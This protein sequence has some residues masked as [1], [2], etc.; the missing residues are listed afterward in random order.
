VPTLEGIEIMQLAIIYRDGKRIGLADAAP[1]GIGL[2]QWFHRNCAAYSMDHAIQHEGYSVEYVE[3]ID[4][5]DVESLIGDICAHAG[6][7]MEAAFVPFSRSRNA[8]PGKDG[9]AWRSLNWR[10]RIFH[11][12]AS[13][14]ILETD[15]SQGEGHAPAYKKTAAQMETAARVMGRP[16]KVA[17]AEMIAHEIETGKIAETHSWHSG[18]SGRKPIPAPSIGD[19]MQSLARDADALD[20]GCF[21]EWA[22]DLGYDT[23]SREAESIYR[24]CVEIA[25][26]LRAGLGS[27]LLAEIRLA[28]SFN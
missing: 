28:A 25:T 22:Q 13:A 20:A 23:D 14:P 10:I 8:K 17:K 19:V 18:V 21:E 2:I 4:C 24:A 5:G 16:V 3:E 12:R 1:Q 6:V 7:T 15:Y 11:R 26:K 9:K 27:S